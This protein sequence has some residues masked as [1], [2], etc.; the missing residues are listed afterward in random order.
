[1][2]IAFLGSLLFSVT[3][4]CQ[5]DTAGTPTGCVEDCNRSLAEHGLLTSGMESVCATP[6]L[7]RAHFQCLVNL[8]SAKSYGRAVVYSISI[9]SATGAN[10]IPLHPIEVRQP[11][12]HKRGQLE[13]DT[14]DSITA[15]GQ[16]FDLARNLAMAL[17]CNTG[18]DGLV[19]VS[20]G[21][22]EPRATTSILKNEDMTRHS[23]STP[24][25]SHEPAT[26]PL[27]GAMLMGGSQDGSMSTSTDCESSAGSQ[28]TACSTTT[29]STTFSTLKQ[30]TTPCHS[31]ETRFSY[32]PTSTIPSS[33]Y[34]GASMTR[35]ASSSERTWMSEN[36][37]LTEGPRSGQTS[38]CQGSS[39]M[40]SGYSAS[41]S[42]AD[43]MATTRTS[44]QS[45]SQ[46]SECSK[47][48]AESGRSSTPTSS[49]HGS[50]S[51]SSITQTKSTSEAFRP[52]A[53]SGSA[54][55]SASRYPAVS[56]VQTTTSTSSSSWLSSSSAP[57]TDRSSSSS[58]SLTTTSTES[59]SS[60]IRESASSARF[61]SGSSSF[62]QTSS[63]YT[64]SITLSI[65]SS[66]THV[67]RP[68]SSSDTNAGPAAY[69][70]ATSSL[71]PSYVPPLEEYDYGNP[72]PAYDF[73]GSRGNVYAVSSSPAGSSTVTSSSHG[74]PSSTGQS[75]TTDGPALY[76]TTGS[77]T[78]TQ[79]TGVASLQDVSG[80]PEES[81]EHREAVKVTLISSVEGEFR[82]TVVTIQQA[83]AASTEAPSQLA[84]NDPP[85]EEIKDTGS[86][87]TAP[88][89]GVA[90]AS[91]ESRDGLSFR[92]ETPM[93]AMLVAKGV[94]LGP[95]GPGMIR[96]GFV[97]FLVY[98]AV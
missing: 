27:N 20:L 39:S 5:R 86:S 48:T 21:A 69:T 56:S 93:P 51:S 2:R 31:D 18:E 78:T 25:P 59:C 14:S 66:F 41:T 97:V 55:S 89:V 16:D 54:C 22:F 42:Y 75:Q 82:T 9:C 10:I 95:S 23:P 29:Q 68:T 73:T 11:R 96:T 50:S 65:T 64:T 26:Q 57:C 3:A 30:T 62:S 94:N 87:L 88:V 72:P 76:G 60:L 15:R 36:R 13:E 53:T 90:N 45:V 63:S 71:P 37:T 32:M 38:S 92:T 40:T 24:I 28:E 74:T 67:T 34:G 46:T 77:A 83:E 4:R 81:A 19:T 91:A 44:R 79:M 43:A 98:W 80:T 49:M 58:S 8:C 84:L 12:S 33:V 52:A 7:Q 47:S 85:E 61:Y 70:F 6:Q 1:M 35:Q 17:T